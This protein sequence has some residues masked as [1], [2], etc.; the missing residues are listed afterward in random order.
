[1]AHSRIISSVDIVDFLTLKRTIPS[2]MVH[3]GMVRISKYDRSA[4]L[5][6]LGRFIRF[7]ASAILR[8]IFSLIVVMVRFI[9]LPFLLAALRLL[10]RLVWTSLTAT[11]TGPGLYIDR[12]ASEWTLRILEMGVQRDD[13]DQIYS[14]CRF[15]VASRIVLGWVV[16]IIFTVAILRVVIRFFI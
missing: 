5:N 4:N 14:L 1:M 2:L 8:L 15:A 9:V 6:L 10:R 16:A 7:L 12:L 3:E 13:I 11:V